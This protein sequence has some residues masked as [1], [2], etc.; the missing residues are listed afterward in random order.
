MQQYPLVTIVGGS[1][2]IGRHT[3][4]HFAK[5]GWRVRVLVRDTVKAEFIKMAGYPGQVVLDH[6]DVARPETLEG[7]FAGS[8]AVVN[9]VGILYP[10][11]RQKF[12]AVHVRGA[13]A[14]AAQAAK[15]GAATL[16]QLSAISAGKSEANY[17]R[18]KLAGEEAARAAFPGAVML[19]PS[20]VVGPEDGFFQR[21]ARMG[22]LLPVLPLIRGGKTKFQPVLVTDVAS[23]IFHAATHAEDAG[24]IF[25]LAGPEVFSFR[26]LLLQMK[27]I[28]KRDVALVPLP[29][30][31]A[32]LV[33][34]GSEIAPFAPVIT[35]DQLRLLKTDAVM[36]DGA[37]GF[38]QLG[39]SPAAIGS[40]LPTY[41]ARYIK[42]A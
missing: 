33:A 39:I 11:G 31:L 16:V 14:V 41:L 34:M 37:A 12:D 4:K 23:A 28:T 2:F 32:G 27:A 17:A 8:T 29:C 38:A 13:K 15:A 25:E 40:Q 1:G 9:L 30:P 35:C 5:A 18:T 10:R 19:R 20:L 26:E 36:G 24:K 22:S 7:K 3:V 42:Q 21:F 6:A